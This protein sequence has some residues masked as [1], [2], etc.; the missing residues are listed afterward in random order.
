MFQVGSGSGSYPEKRVTDPDPDPSAQKSTDPTD[1]DP[2]AFIPAL[3]PCIR[4]SMHV[5]P[6]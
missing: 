4:L 2:H 5:D 1:L 3:G 6:V